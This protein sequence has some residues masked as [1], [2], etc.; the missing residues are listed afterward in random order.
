[1]EED[2]RKVVAENVVSLL[3]LDGPQAKGA[4][5][6]LIRLGISN[7][8]ATRALKGETNLGL[9]KIAELA[10][11]LKVKPWQLLVPDLDPQRLPSLEPA[12]FRWPFR[13]IDP[14][15]IMDLAGTPAQQVEN[16]LLGVLAAVGLQ[17][18]KHGSR[19]EVVPA[20]LT[21]KLI[22]TPSPASVRLPAF[23]QVPLPTSDQP[24]SPE[25]SPPPPSRR[26][27]AAPKAPSKAGRK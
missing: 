16:G 25:S 8:D 2:L 1:M 23:G 27:A 19:A 18:I 12:T 20:G 21:R 26:S 3:G 4:T 5:A 22:G 24:A 14:A 15:A 6:K 17:T 9:G 13:K 11:A 10:S 7:G